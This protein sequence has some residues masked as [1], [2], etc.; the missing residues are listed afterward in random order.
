MTKLA[1]FGGYLA[2]NSDPPPGNPVLW[3]GWR[4]L[5]DLQIGAEIY[6]G[7]TCGQSQASPEGYTQ[8]ASSKAPPDARLIIEGKQP[9]DHAARLS[10]PP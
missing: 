6:Q 2:R 1:R 7:Q 4:R 9:R 8:A 5:I 10:I 3:R